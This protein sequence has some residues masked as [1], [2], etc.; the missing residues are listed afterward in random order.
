MTFTV[1]GG[2]GPKAAQPPP[3]EATSVRPSKSPVVAIVSGHSINQQDMWPQLI[4]AS[5]SEIL[6]EIFLGHAIEDAVVIAGLPQVTDEDIDREKSLLL[7]TLLEDDPRNLESIL[8]ERGFGENRLRELCRRTAGLRKLVQP[9]IV[10]T[11]NSINR[12]FALIHGPKYPA[13]IIVTSTLE[14]ASIAKQ[15]IIDGESFSVVAA[16]ISIDQSATQ[17]GF[18][19]PISLADPLWPTAVREV[20]GSMTIGECSAPILIKDRWMIVTITGSPAPAS[21]NLSEVRQEMRTLSK[22]A[23]EQLEM[24]RLSES[25]LSR[26]STTILDPHIQRAMHAK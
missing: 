18:I 24:E 9:K 26:F 21:V 7:R 13:K 1:F 6:Q 10:V 11:D 22:L 2:C 16:T 12:M 15:R 14:E 17:G 4:E 20:I 25:L 5:G 3:M 19:N 23:M 8:A